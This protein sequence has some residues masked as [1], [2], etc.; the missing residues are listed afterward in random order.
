MQHFRRAHAVLA[1]NKIFYHA[2]AQRTGAIQ[3]NQ[4]NQI[5]EFFRCQI[6]NQFGH[7]LRFQLEH[8][9]RIAAPQHSAGSVVVQRDVF[10]INFFAGSFFNIAHSVADN[11]QSPQPQQIHFEQA[12]VFNFI[13][14]ILSNDKAFV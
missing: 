12:E 14:V 2:G 5:A 9:L 10:N 8:A 3:R 4:R 1:F 13:L 6:H 7:A 11:G